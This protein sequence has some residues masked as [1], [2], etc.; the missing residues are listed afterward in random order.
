MTRLSTEVATSLSAAARHGIV[1]GNRRD[2]ADRAAVASGLAIWLPQTCL[3]ADYLQLT[4]RGRKALEAHQRR[5]A[6]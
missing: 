1:P 3:G 6:S 2:P 5:R 4:D